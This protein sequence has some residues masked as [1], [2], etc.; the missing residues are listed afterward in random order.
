MLCGFTNS[1]AGEHRRQTAREAAGRAWK[2]S[3]LGNRS[4]KRS[5]WAQ[6]SRRYSSSR[7]VAWSTRPNARAQR[8]GNRHGL[9]LR[10]GL[11]YPPTLLSDVAPCLHGGSGRDLWTRGCV[12]DLSHSMRSRETRQQ[13]PLRIG[14]QRVD[15]EHQPCARYRSEGQGRHHL[16]QLHQC[17]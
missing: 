16:G 2:N 1:R 17:V 10:E 14:R 13:H 12:H 11:F 6:S 15:R 3:A 4:T 9:V 5:T 7:F 8:C